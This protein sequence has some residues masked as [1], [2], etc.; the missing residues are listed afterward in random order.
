MIKMIVTQR[1]NIGGV[2]L[3]FTNHPSKNNNCVFAVFNHSFGLKGNSSKPDSIRKKLNIAHNTKINLESLPTI[4]KY[5]NNKQKT[6]KG[7]LVINK[8][9]DIIVNITNNKVSTQI[10]NLITGEEFDYNHYVKIYIDNDHYYSFD[11]QLSNTCDRCG[12]VYKNKHSK[13]R[14]AQASFLEKGKKE[15]DK[16]WIRAVKMKKQDEMN[17]LDIMVYWDT[18]TFP[19]ILNKSNQVY[20]SG[21][22]TDGNYTQHYGEEAMS[23]TVDAFIQMEDKIIT[24]YNGSKFDFY[25]LIKELNKRNV[26]VSNFIVSNGRI[27]GFSFGSNRVFDLYLFINAS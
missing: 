5:F 8:N 2:H 17:Y 4:L 26:K 25:F 27:L 19:D 14:I 20:A 22:Q 23:E 1:V 12:H 16:R 11:I 24:A 7:L 10:V 15:E 18:E 9:Y 13:C 21:Y 3:T 6:N